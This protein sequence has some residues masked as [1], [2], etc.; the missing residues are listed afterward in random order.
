MADKANYVVVF[1][2]EKEV[3]IRDV[4]PWD[5]HLT[6]TNDAERVVEDLSVSLNGRKLSYYDSDGELGVLRVVGGKFAGFA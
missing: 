1:T 6:I 5:R 4:G 3:C 2:D